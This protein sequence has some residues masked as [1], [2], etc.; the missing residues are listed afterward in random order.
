MNLID[1]VMPQVEEAELVYIP[2]SPVQ[3]AEEGNILTFDLL[4]S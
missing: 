2:G 1:E 3:D 4:V